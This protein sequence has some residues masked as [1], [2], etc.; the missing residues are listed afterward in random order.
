M[1]NYVNYDHGPVGNAIFN[2]T[3]RASAFLR[4]HMWLYWVLQFTWGI[5][6]TAGGALIALACLIVGGKPSRH[7]SHF[8]VTIG[9]N[10]GGLECGCGMVVSDRMGEAWT[11]HTKNHEAGHNFQN[12]VWG[13]FA[14]I[15]FSAPSA[16]RYW[17]QRARLAR[18]DGKKNKPY[19]SAYFEDAASVVGEL[20][21]GTLSGRGA[22]SRRKGKKGSDSEK[23]A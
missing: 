8:V 3:L 23:R 6:G 20:F 19:D 15:L 4:R 2:A 16:V 9:N 12:A 13:P 11:E 21:Y 10:W 14:L 17:I 22:K 7:H 5:L 1:Y 18:G